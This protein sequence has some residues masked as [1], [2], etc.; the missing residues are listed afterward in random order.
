MSAKIGAPLA[1]F[2]QNDSQ[3]VTLIGRGG[4]RMAKKSR[5]GLRNDVFARFGIPYQLHFGI[6]G[7]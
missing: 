6:R 5:F 1:I 7:M 4:A 2:V 3:W